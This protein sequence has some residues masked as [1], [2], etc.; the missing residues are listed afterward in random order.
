[1]IGQDPTMEKSVGLTT[2]ATMPTTPCKTGALPGNLHILIDST[3]EEKEKALQPRLNPLG[4]RKKRSTL[5]SIRS[6]PVRNR[7]TPAQN[8]STPTPKSSTPTP[9][10]PNISNSFRLNSSHFP[11]N[12]LYL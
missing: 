5:S 3:Q 8:R 6:K 12:M 10:L 1:F 9:H 2:K 4:K 11:K 7:S